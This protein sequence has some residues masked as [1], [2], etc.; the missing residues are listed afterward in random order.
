MANIYWRPS[1][2]RLKFPVRA[3]QAGFSF[4]ASLVPYICIIRPF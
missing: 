4:P 2:E 3:P 1:I